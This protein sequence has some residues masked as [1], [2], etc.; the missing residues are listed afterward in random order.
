[1][2]LSQFIYITKFVLQ[3]ITSDF[4]LG[5]WSMTTLSAGTEDINSKV[6]ITIATADSS[7]I[8]TSGAYASQSVTYKVI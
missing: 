4:T 7:F 1:M 6:G 2:L 5:V 8:P 3:S